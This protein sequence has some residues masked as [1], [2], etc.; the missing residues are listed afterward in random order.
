MAIFIDREKELEYLK[1]YILKFPLPS[2]DVPRSRQ[3]LLVVG[4]KGVGKTALLRKLMEN[5][6]ENTVFIYIEFG[7]P[8]ESYV[9]LMIDML[10]RIQESLERFKPH[11]IDVLTKILR[12][13]GIAIDIAIGKPIE[14][15]IELLTAPSTIEALS[16]TRPTLL[17][18]RL[19]EELCRVAEKENVRLVT[20]YD[21]FQSFLKTIVGS[22]DR[23]QHLLET[24]IVYLSK[25]Q[26][27]GFTNCRGY[28][29]RILAA[30]DFTTYTL[31][32]R[33]IGTY[34]TVMYLDELREEEVVKFLT[35][36]LKIKIHGVKYSD[37]F[38]QYTVKLLG[39]NPSIILRFIDK[40]RELRE[41]RYRD[42]DE[43]VPEITNEIIDELIQ[44]E[45]KELQALSNKEKILI[46]KLCEL[47]KNDRTSIDVETLR[48][49][50]ELKE[51][52]FNEILTNLLEKNVLQVFAGKA[53]GYEIGF[54][55][56]LL[57]YAARKLKV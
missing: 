20:I 15:L 38:L 5:G 44:D 48:H 14:K 29:I 18:K 32:S 2:E 16:R 36:L 11:W 21:E 12:S 54:Q 35:E 27:W 49:R 45:I 23:Y 46:K 57:L 9:D 10:V 22:M 19:E 34:I 1:S 53:P 31:L 28:P 26:E 55:N 3:V 37:L 4:A 17:L 56:K 33:Y 43:F 30:S 51:E 42:L 13:I 6:L 41:T 25:T 39:G 50:S 8:Y 24:F 7:G 47:L 52:E 40:L